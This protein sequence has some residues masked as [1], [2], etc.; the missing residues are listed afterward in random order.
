[1]KIQV[2]ILHTWKCNFYEINHLMNARMNKRTIWYIPLIPFQFVH[3]LCH[4]SPV[5]I[6]KKHL[7]RYIIRHKIK[8]MKNSQVSYKFTLITGTIKILDVCITFGNL[9]IF[10][11][12]SS[13]LLT[14]LWNFDRRTDHRWHESRSHWACKIIIRCQQCKSRYTCK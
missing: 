6:F 13:R 1:M 5:E 12:S 14:I 11:V 10:Q 9:N 2:C 3:T 8:S 4:Q 7:Q